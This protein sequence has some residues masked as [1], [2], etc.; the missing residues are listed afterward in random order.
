MVF[1]FFESAMPILGL[2]IGHR[3][4]NSIGSSAPYVGGGLLVSAGVYTIVQARRAHSN[5]S[6]A[7][8]RLGS[9]IAT[10]AALSVDNLIV[11]FAIGTYKVPIIIAAFV[12]AAVSVAM[13]LLGLEIGHRLG[14]VVERWSAE[15]GGV[16][17]IGVGFSIAFGV[18]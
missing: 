18:L 5:E 1:G 14:F 9:L 12:I 17:L 2:L 4:A 7:S 15:F 16:V 13:S 6:R 11:G 8:S 3:L 10:S